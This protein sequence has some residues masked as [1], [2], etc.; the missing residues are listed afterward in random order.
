MKEEEII[1]IA[2]D[3]IPDDL[4]I[5]TQW[6]DINAGSIDGKLILTFDQQE[7]QFFAQ[8]KKEVREH[9]LTNIEAAAINNHPLIVI[10]HYLRPKVK[11]QLRQKNIAY[12]ERNG[13]IFFREANKLVLIDGNK[14]VNLTN[15]TGNRAFTDTGLR[16]IF[17]FL[18]NNDLINQPYREIAKQVDT[19][20][21]NVNNILAGL[22]KETFL[23]R[24]NADLKYLKKKELFNKWMDNYKVTLQPKLKIGRFRFANENNFTQWR[25]I[26]L[27][28]GKTFWGG[29]PAGDLFTDYLRPG[30][31]TIYTDE[32]RI[33]VMKNYRLIPDPDG[34]VIVYK[35]FWNQPN[36][37]HPNAVPPILAYADL[38][39]TGDNRCQNVA[40]M[41]WDKYLANEF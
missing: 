10:A 24:M 19:A 35:K 26:E 17:Q 29:E 33:E 36:T 7:I 39:N 22:E 21:G 38:M 6:E 30:E 37:E 3:N 12:L 4:G 23:M 8:I 1:H 32:N 28:E 2:I 25:N 18:I 16:V 15:E 13:N 31:L 20:L 41:I 27:Q 40:Q 14:P 34:D 9:Q 11:E 5:T